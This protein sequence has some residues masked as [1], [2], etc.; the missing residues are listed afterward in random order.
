MQIKN[1][2][3]KGYGFINEDS[4]LITANL[5]GVFDGATGLIK[6][7][8][9]EGK[10]GGFLAA[11]IAKDIFEKNI[12]K[13]LIISIEEISKELRNKMQKAHINLQ[14]TSA[15]WTTSASAVRISDEYIEYIQLGD[16]PIIII[17]KDETIK[18]FATDH[19]VET[20]ILWKKLVDDGIKE[21][22][23]HNAMEKQLLKIRSESNITHGVLNGSPDAMKFVLQGKIPKKDIKTILI[24]SDGINN[25]QEN[26]LDPKDFKK[27][28]R[29]F[30]SGGLD[31]IKNYVRQVENS[32]P[33]CL[34]YPR[35]KQHDDLTAIA[36]NF[37]K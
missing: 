13:P 4:I 32:D 16:S 17:Y 19:D 14:D 7:T 1:L 6:Y 25:P 24:F 23:H 27:I 35:F 11:Q 29:L 2:C 37:N 36:I 12:D 3:D 21:I 34:K 8:D 9:S 26:P 18:S 10:T 20:M 33:Q 5:F 30:K 28:V 31:K 15:A 22:R